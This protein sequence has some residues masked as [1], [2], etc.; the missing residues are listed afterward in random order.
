MSRKRT[1]TGEKMSEAEM[2]RVI[3]KH[4]GLDRPVTGEE[5]R[6]EVENL[7][8]RDREEIL[9]DRHLE[10]FIALKLDREEST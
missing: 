6:L 10:L 5:V 1:K 3:R 8:R 2:A 9:F 7:R 4:Y